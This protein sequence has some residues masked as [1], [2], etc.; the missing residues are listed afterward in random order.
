KYVAVFS[1]IFSHPY[2]KF[3]RQTIGE[4][5]SGLRFGSLFWAKKEVGPPSWQRVNIRLRGYDFVVLERYQSY[6]HKLAR[7]MGFKVISAVTVYKP[8]SKV[9]QTLFDISKYERNVQIADLPASSSS[10][11]FDIIN[12]H[13]PI[14][15][16]LTVKIHEEAD[17]EIRY[18][19]DLEIKEQ[20]CLVEELNK[21][22]AGV[23]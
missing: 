4:L 19:P 21:E 9:V 13:L 16:E 14:G 12:T 17:D 7:N 10:L 18:I 5:G 23:K 6:V 8:H 20:M 22:L 2:D 15:V 11:L 3:L 1:N